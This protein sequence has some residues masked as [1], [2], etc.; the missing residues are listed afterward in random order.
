MREG[1]PSATSSR[2]CVRRSR[3]TLALAL[4][5]SKPCRCGSPGRP[6]RNLHASETS[7]TCMSPMTC[8]PGWPTSG[9]SSLPWAASWWREGTPISRCSSRRSNARSID[10]AKSSRSGWRLVTAYDRSDLISRVGHTLLRALAEEVAVVVLVISVFLL[11]GRSALRPAADAAGRAPVTFGA[12]YRSACPATIM[13]LGGIGIA[14]GMAVDAD[15]VALEA[16]HRRVEARGHGA[17]RVNGDGQLI[18]AAGCFAP[19]ILTS[20]RDHGAQ[21]LAG[22]RV[23]GG[24]GQVATP[25]GVRPRHWSSSRRR[26]STVTLAP[27]LRD[28]LLRGRMMPEF[29]NPSRAVWSGAIDRS[30]TS[31]WRDRR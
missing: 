27:A 22:V 30:C 2:R 5:T 4:T 18:A 23:H 1:S 13:S 12:M 24:D 10:S 16:C 15:V 14:L 31:R 3:R 19:A 28:R 25:A 17:S 26:S 7:A 11:H 21:L 29:D 9:A 8:R 6:G 20:L